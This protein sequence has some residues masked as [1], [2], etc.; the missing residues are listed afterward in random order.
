M[1]GRRRD[2]NL[3]PVKIFRFLPLLLAAVLLAACGSG[4]SAPKVQAGDVAEVASEHI[5][6]GE[7]QAALAEAEAS[8]KSQGQSIPAPGSSEY[9]AMRTAVVEQLVQQAELDLQAGKLGVSVTNADVAKQ[10]AKLKKA[11]FKG[12]EKAYNAELKKE[13]VSDADVRQ[14][15]RQALLSEKIY[16]AI[17]KGATVTKSAIAAYYASNLSQYQQKATRSV[18]EI[19]VGK[20]QKLANQLYAQLKGGAD[21]ATLAKKYSKDPGSKNQG[22]KYTATQGSDVTEFDAAVF[23]PTAKTGVLLKPVDTKQYGWFVIEPL[24]AINPAKVTP[25][26]KAAAGIRK[27]LQS[28]K[29]QTVASTWMKGIEEGYCSGSQIAYGTAYAPSPDPCAALK[30]PP[31]TTT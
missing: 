16:T 14:Y 5:T 4:S 28:T 21:F 9:G 27:Q 22:G 25:E 12:S 10:L 26:S 24:A 20:N 18:E 11:N 23:A 19:L 2:E 8:A 1:T 17:T 30:S 29:A 15:I 13:H 6:T 7:Y 31:P 3:P